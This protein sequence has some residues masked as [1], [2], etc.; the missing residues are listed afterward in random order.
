MSYKTYSIQFLFLRKF[1]I[2]FFV[3]ISISSFSQDAVIK[4]VI[5]DGE[6]NEPLIGGNVILETSLNLIFK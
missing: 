4:G 6:E 1:L 3:S 5:I 2:L